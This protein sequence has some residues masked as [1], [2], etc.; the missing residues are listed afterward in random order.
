[1]ENGPNSKSDQISIEHILELEITMKEKAKM[2][3]QIQNISPK[4]AY[5]NL[6]KMSIK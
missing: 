4:E 5:N 1:M 3:A 2:V 6:L